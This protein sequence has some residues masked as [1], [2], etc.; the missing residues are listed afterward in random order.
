MECAYTFFVAKLK[1]NLTVLRDGIDKIDSEIVNLISQR[2]DLV[3]KVSLEKSKRKLSII[4][5]T[6]ESQILADVARMANKRGHDEVLFKKIFR[7]II[8]CTIAF[9]KKTCQ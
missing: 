5:R 8:D 3:K 6:R 9:E 7:T 4:D 1:D 2:F